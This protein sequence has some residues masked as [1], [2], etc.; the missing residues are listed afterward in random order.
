MIVRIGKI[1]RLDINGKVHYIN[2]NSF[3]LKEVNN[4]VNFLQDDKLV[5]RVPLSDLKQPIEE[6]IALT[7]ETQKGEQGKQGETG[8]DGTNGTNGLNGSDGKDGINGTD[9]RD[10]IDGRNGLSGSNGKDGKD[11]KDF[12]ITPSLISEIRGS[13]GKDGVDGKDGKDGKDGEKGSD[14]INGT[15]GTNG[16]NGI[17]GQSFVWS[18]EYDRKDTYEKNEVVEYQGASWIAITDVP[19]NEPPLNP[20]Q[21]KRYWDLSAARGIQGIQGIS[22]IKGLDGQG[23]PTGGTTGQHLAKIDGTDYNTQWVSPEVDTNDKVG[24]SSN[25]TTPSY[26]DDKIIGTANKITLTELNDGG[27][28]DLQINIGSDIFDKSSNDSDDI[29]EGATNLFLTSAER[30]DISDNTAKRHDAATVTDSSNIDLTITGQDITADLINTTVSAGSYTNADITVDA[31]GR[32]TAAS[33]GTGAL[34]FAIDLDSAEATVT[35]V[36]A[37][38]RTTFTVTHSLGTLDVKPEVYRLSNG[39]TVGWR[40]ERTGINTVEASRNG[41]IGDGLFRIVI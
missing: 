4:G 3:S 22:G 17:D 33:N 34:S 38:G 11:G 26:L 30:T 21:N 20:A 19:E 36:F 25:D 28:E 8:R 10:G 37:G 9:G 18:G 15:N 5:I 40:I 23:V 27:D 31:N 39:R 32:L 14:G 16:I 7:D 24:V 41:N 1:L 6:I 13:D 12:E 2:I 29:T 35:R